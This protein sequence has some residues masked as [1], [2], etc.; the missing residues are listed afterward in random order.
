MKKQNLRRLGLVIMAGI[1]LQFWGGGAVSMAGNTIHWE[2]YA[3]GLARAKSE[4]KH[5]FLY[6][7]ADWCSYCKKLKQTTF[8]DKRVVAYLAENFVSISVDTDKDT[9][10]ATEWKVRGL[11]TL[12]FLDVDGKKISHLPGF[13]TP[14]QFMYVLEFIRTDS[15]NSMS[16]QEFLG[17]KL[18]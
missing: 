15:Y 18:K 7:H 8:K 2:D 9:R 10:R 16:F 13:V 6:F 14:D 4:E 17:K 5:V 3:A 11:P 12:W 1:L